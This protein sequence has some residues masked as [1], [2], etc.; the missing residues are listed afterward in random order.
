[1]NLQCKKV[2]YEYSWK[3]FYTSFV[4]SNIL[5]TT[6]NHSYWTI[7]PGNQ[8]FHEELTLE[9]RG[10]IIVNHR[11]L[12]FFVMVVYISTFTQNSYKYRVNCSIT[13][14]IWF[15]ISN[16]RQSSYT[17]SIYTSYNISRNKSCDNFAIK[18]WYFCWSS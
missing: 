9:I 10:I 3:M 11:C 17:F 2:V 14:F 6:H 13:M 18:T 15:T 5:R 12:S 7:N 4:K 8:R 16:S 1:M